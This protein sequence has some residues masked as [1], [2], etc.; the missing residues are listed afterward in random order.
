MSQASLPIVYLFNIVIPTVSV[1]FHPKI[2]HS[3]HSSRMWCTISLDNQK[4]G[5]RGRRRVY[6]TVLNL[7]EEESDVYL[8][9]EEEGGKEWVLY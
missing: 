5:R 8:C 9:G 2:N 7:Q 4:Y 6:Q 1:M 3:V